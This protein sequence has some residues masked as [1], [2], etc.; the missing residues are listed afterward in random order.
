MA[1]DD[2]HHFPGIFVGAT[3]AEDETNFTYGIEYEYKF[4]SK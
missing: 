3:H 1:A 2:N 4:T